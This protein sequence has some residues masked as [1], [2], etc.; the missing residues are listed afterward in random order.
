MPK[1]PGVNHL[2]AVKAVIEPGED[3]GFVAHV[4]A[5]RGCWSQGHNRAEA[6]EHIREAI[7]AWLET[8]QDKSERPASPPDVELVRLTIM[9]LLCPSFPS[10]AVVKLVRP[11]R[12]PGGV[13]IGSAEVVP[14]RVCECMGTYKVFAVNLSDLSIDKSLREREAQ[15]KLWPLLGCELRQTE[16]LP[17]VCGLH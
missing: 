10:S 2:K 13:L 17:A 3:F 7:A 15:S 14:V 1:L 8:E 9:D 4:P 5:L 16:E 12:K 11:S 6:L